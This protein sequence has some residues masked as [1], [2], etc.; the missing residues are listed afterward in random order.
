[1]AD[2]SGLSPAEQ[3][4]LTTWALLARIAVH[5]GAG[6]VLPGSFPPDVEAEYQR[7]RGVAETLR[8]EADPAAHEPFRRDA[9]ALLKRLGDREVAG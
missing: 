4:R 5:R 8:Q 3:E 6:A 2:R 1:M 9:R 7:L